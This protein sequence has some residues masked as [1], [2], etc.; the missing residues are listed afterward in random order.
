M[1]LRL[2]LGAAPVHEHRGCAVN[3]LFGQDIAGGEPALRD[4]FAVSKNRGATDQT[5]FFTSSKR[6]LR[7]SS[8][9]MP[10]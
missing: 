9:E 1:R 6:A 4:P 10:E 5:P 8:R 2:A 7:E 3:L